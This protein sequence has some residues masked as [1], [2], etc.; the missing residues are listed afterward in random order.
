MG[1]GEEVK[2][3]EEETLQYIKGENVIEGEK[4]VLLRGYHR[5]DDKKKRIFALKKEKP[6]R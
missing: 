6:C 4:T 2:T 5:E 3:S 1:E